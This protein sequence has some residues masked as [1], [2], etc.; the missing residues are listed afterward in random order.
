M[1][2]PSNYILQQYLKAI[3]NDSGLTKDKIYV[4]LADFASERFSS[5][6]GILIVNDDKE[7]MVYER[8]FFEYKEDFGVLTMGDTSGA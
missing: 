4:A 8:T 7:L 3:V 6:Y 1:Y 5:G 2:K